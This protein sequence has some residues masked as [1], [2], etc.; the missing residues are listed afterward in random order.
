MPFTI[1]DADQRTASNALAPPTLTNG[2]LWPYNNSLYLYG[3]TTSRLNDS[4][5]GYQPP[6]SEDTVMWRFNTE[7][8]QWAPVELTV[9]GEKMPRLGGGANV[10]AED[11]GLAFYYGGQVDNGTSSDTANDNRI[12]Y[13]NK[14]FVFNL[15]NGSVQSLPVDALATYGSSGSQMVYIPYIGKKGILVNFGGSVKPATAADTR[16]RGDMVG[17]IPTLYIFI[18][19]Y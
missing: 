15:G 10:V 8:S 14:F 6:T 11:K 12:T 18:R 1:L 4:F 13:S 2:A 17:S 19:R 7:S 3:G 5:V 9:N 16:F